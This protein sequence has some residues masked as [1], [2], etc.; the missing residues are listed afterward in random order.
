MLFHTVNLKRTIKQAREREG[1]RGM[2]EECKMKI[3]L[4]KKQIII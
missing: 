4:K 3:K 1:E 2:G